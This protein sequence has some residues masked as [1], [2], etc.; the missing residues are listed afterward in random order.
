MELLKQ[1]DEYKRIALVAGHHELAK[2]I[3]EVLVM[4]EREDKEQFLSRSRKP[5]QIDEYGRS[6]TIGRRKESHA[7]V[8]VIPTRVER[9]TPAPVPEQA[10]PVQDGLAGLYASVPTLPKDKRPAVETVPVTQILIN[11]VPLAEYLYVPQ[12]SLPCASSPENPCSAN[13][14]D[15]DHVIR[16]L[17][18]TGLLGAFNVFALARGGGTTG[19]AGAVAVG[20]ARGLAAHVPEVDK[21]LRKGAW[22]TLV[23]SATTLTH[24]HSETHPP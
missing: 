16:P 11:N 9:S 19:Q 24:R 10:A 15:R 13:P 12:Y 4:F 3:E 8:W 18:V 20:I 7:R 21:I 22:W 6:Y 23:L 5:V 14:S 17:K 1:L 2:P